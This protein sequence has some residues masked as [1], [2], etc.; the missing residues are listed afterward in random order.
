MT[1]NK[2]KRA[3]AVGVLAAAALL[4]P[5]AC[6]AALGGEQATVADDQAH[7]KATIRTTQTA[8]YTVHELRAATGTAVR[9]Y[10]SPAGKVFAVAWQGPFLPDMK[11]V[12]G[13]Y[14]EQFARAARAPRKGHGPLSIIEPGLVVQSAGH[15]RAFRGRAYIPEM[16]PADADVESIR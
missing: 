16:L 5:A 1:F 10:V 12:L 4:L 2:R 7:M 13:A 8:A 14:F 9:E 15:M 11:Q 3:M 6:F